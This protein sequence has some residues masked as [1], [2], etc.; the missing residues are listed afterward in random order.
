MTLWFTKS[1][2]TSK[3]LDKAGY[4][5]QVSMVK[6]SNGMV[7]G[8]VM[9]VLVVGIAGGYMF[10]SKYS[11]EWTAQ[12]QAEHDKVADIKAELI[13]LGFPEDILDDLTA[14]DI[15][16]C[17]GAVRVIVNVEEHSVNESDRLRSWNEEDDYDEKELRAT[18]VAVRLPG[19]AERWQVFHHL[20]FLNNTSF[21]GTEAVWLWPADSINGWVRGTDVTGRVLYTKDDVNYTA[22]YYSLASEIYTINSLIQGDETSVNVFGTFS[23]PDEGEAHRCYVS[24]VFEATEG[25]LLANAWI[26]Y[27]HQKSLLNYPAVTAKDSQEIEFGSSSVFELVQDKL[28]FDPWEY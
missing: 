21:C 15:E 22:P 8:I 16:A 14:E 4:A 24:Y 23:M 28:V 11:M 26:N 5:I 12:S 7:A 20:L 6:I 19:E 13:K 3:E 2:K 9:A 25:E 1:F 17:E 10:F 18:C 27:V